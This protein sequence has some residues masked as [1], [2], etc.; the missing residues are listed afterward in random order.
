MPKDQAKVNDSPLVEL[1]TLFP[2]G[3]RATVKEPFDPEQPDKERTEVRVRVRAL[4]ARETARMA[5]AL[6]KIVS[7]SEQ[8]KAHVELANDHFDDA[9]ELIAVATDHN[10]KWIGDLDNAD[11]VRLWKAFIG[12]NADFFM[13][14]VGLIAMGRRMGLSASGA[15]PIASS[16]SP[17]TE[18]PTP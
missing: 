7:S 16:S 5:A 14:V 9:C 2:I 15:G 1:Q 3:G 18:S 17:S 13:E 8:G 10:A 6:V 12:A 11:F 4:S